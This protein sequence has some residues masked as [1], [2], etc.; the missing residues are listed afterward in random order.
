MTEEHSLEA[1]TALSDDAFLYAFEAGTLPAD[2]FGHR[3]HVRL[4]WLYLRQHPVPDVLVRYGDGLRRFATRHGKANLYHE[5]ITWAFLLIIHE[6]M[7]HPEAADTW[8][9]FAAA[10]PDLLCSKPSILERYY[11][12][13]T[14]ASPRARAVFVM[15][16][17]FE[18]ADNRKP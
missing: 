14:L 5:T 4:A 9:A 8:P 16:D 15:P 12:P 17:R 7:A 2:A 13:A 10:H 18:A 3:E 1:A 6:R 11:H